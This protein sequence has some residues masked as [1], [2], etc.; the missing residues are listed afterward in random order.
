M[1]MAA[2]ATVVVSNAKELDRYHPQAQIF[3]VA[4]VVAYT[5]P[6]LCVHPIHSIAHILDPTT[7]THHR[8]QQPSTI[9]LPWDLGYGVQYP[10]SARGSLI[11]CFDAVLWV[12]VCV[13]V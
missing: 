1:I 9:I 13:H 4:V 2:V 7:M 8:N 10:G 12:C 3:F 5:V 11:C 6:I